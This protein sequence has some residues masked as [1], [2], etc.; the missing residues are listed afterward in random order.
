ML[1]HNIGIE[2][3]GRTQKGGSWQ[4]DSSYA[5][6]FDNRD[7]QKPSRAVWT[8]GWR[9]MSSG[10]S[11][12]LQIY[13]P[14]MGLEW[15]TDGHRIHNY[16]TSVVLRQPREGGVLEVDG[17]HKT[18]GPFHRFDGGISEHR[19]TKCGGY[20]VVLMFQRMTQQKKENQ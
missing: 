16:V 19:V 20:R 7:P 6:R 1:G 4:L 17:V 5:H 2:F 13:R 14:G 8:F 9:R 15:H 10:W 3:S 12:M 11:I 18:W